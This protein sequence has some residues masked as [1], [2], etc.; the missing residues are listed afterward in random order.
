MY[1][2]IFQRIAAVKVNP[3]SAVALDDS[4]SDLDK[5]T[6]YDKCSSHSNHKKTM[7]AG[8]HEPDHLLH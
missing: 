8:D 6:A 1:K 5:L 2:K 7:T 4:G 3:K